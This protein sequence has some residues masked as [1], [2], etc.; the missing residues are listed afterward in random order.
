M[1]IIGQKRLQQG[2]FEALAGMNRF[3]GSGG[4][5]GLQVMQLLAPDPAPGT[6]TVTGAGPKPITGYSVS[7]TIARTQGCLYLATLNGQVSAGIGQVGVGFSTDST[8]VWDVTGTLGLFDSKNAGYV[9]C[10]LIEF[11]LLAPGT[12]TVRVLA[13]PGALT[14][15]VQSG[16]LLAF[17]LGV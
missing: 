15:S 5:S 1:S 12:H 7:F 14:L 6:T 13:A 11:N 4:G 9:T 16:D 3:Q 17:A 2:V 10:P 8:S